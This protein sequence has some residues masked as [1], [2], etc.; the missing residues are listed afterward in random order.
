MSEQPTTAAGRALLAAL[1]T[2]LSFTPGESYQPS[3]P[4]RERILAIEAEAAIAAVALDMERLARALSVLGI[5]WYDDPL[6][7]VY[8]AKRIAVEYARL[9][10]TSAPHAPVALD[11]DWLAQAIHDA[12][13]IG[14]PMGPCGG[15]FGVPLDCLCYEQAGD[16]IERYARLASEEKR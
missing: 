2:E 3:G 12:A 10:A 9:A 11:V 15:T 6:M 4:W 14:G 8:D 13:Q 16:L 7:H 5:P 1:D